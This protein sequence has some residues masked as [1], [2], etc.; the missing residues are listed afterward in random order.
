MK[1]L[2]LSLASDGM[3]P[4]TPWI[5]QQI[6]YKSLRPVFRLLCRLGKSLLLRIQETCATLNSAS[7]FLLHR[8]CAEG[9][10]GRLL[11]VGIFGS[12]RYGLVLKGSGG[13]VPDT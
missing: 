2:R 5:Q 6:N 8:H 10:S 9:G 11:A 4:K 3:D 7:A 1:W 13:G 12:G